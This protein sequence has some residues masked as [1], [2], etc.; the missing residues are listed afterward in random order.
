MKTSE[1]ETTTKTPHIPPRT[2]L[3]G[4]CT[5]QASA[6]I[7][8]SACEPDDAK[9]TWDQ[10]YQ[11]TTTRVHETRR[12]TT[13][14]R[15]I[16]R[17]TQQDCRRTLETRRTTTSVVQ[18]SLQCCPTCPKARDG[19]SGQGVER[20]EEVQLNK[21]EVSRRSTDSAEATGDD[22]DHRPRMS[23]KLPDSDDAT[24]AS[25]GRANTMTK[26]GSSED[27]QTKSEGDD[28]TP[29]RAQ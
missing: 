16:Q 14:P 9:T 4:E 18:T 7:D 24:P 2:P 22:D 21:A 28:N 29:G 8:A 17:Q 3:E 13:Q 27:L 26:L 11:S 15:R 12:A 25:G 5:P 6:A 1:D 10:G 23:N 19:E 20:V